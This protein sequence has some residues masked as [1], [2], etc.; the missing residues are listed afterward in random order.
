MRA[1]RIFI[2][3][4]LGVATATGGLWLAR[5]H[6]VYTRESQEFSFVAPVAGRRSP[7]IGERVRMAGADGE[8]LSALY[9]EPR[10]GALVVYV[11]GSPGDG[12]GFEPEMRELSRDGYG[13]LALDMPGYGESP[14]DRTWGASYPRAISVALDFVRARADGSS[15]RIGVH[16]YSMGTAVVAQAAALDQRVG[17]MVLVAAFTTLHE[18]LAAQFRSRVPGMPA[19]ALF[20]ARRSDVDVDAL[21]SRRALQT[22]TAPLLFIA[23]EDDRVV[24][25]AMPRELSAAAE[26]RELWVAPGVGH[27]GFAD[28]AGLAYFDQLRAFWSR[29]LSPNVADP[30]ADTHYTGTISR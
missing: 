2:V 12:L 18:Q 20:A 6:D 24:P 11:H 27:V 22:H 14:G 1:N 25:L 9:L 4:V 28:G 13:A 8:T 5:A 21:D 17:P 23:G 3:C 10:N 7:A 29:T 26:A 30:K 16:G 19:V 15:V